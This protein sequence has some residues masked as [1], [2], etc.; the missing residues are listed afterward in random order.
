MGVSLALV[1]TWAMVYFYNVFSTKQLGATFAAWWH[2][3]PIAPDLTRLIDNMLAAQPLDAVDVAADGM[4]EPQGGMWHKYH[5]LPPA[6]RAWLFD[7]CVH[8]RRLDAVAPPH[9]EGCV[10]WHSH[11]SDTLL[12]WITLMLDMN[13]DSV[14]VSR[15]SMASGRPRVNVVSLPL[16]TP[17]TGQQQALDHIIALSDKNDIARCSTIVVVYGETGVGKSTLC[18]LW[19]Q[20][21]LELRDPLVVR[22]YPNVDILRRG[23]DVEELV[24]RYNGAHS[25][26]VLNIDEIDIAIDRVTGTVPSPRGHTTL[27]TEDKRAFRDLMDILKRIPHSLVFLTTNVTPTE[28]FVRGGRDPSLLGRVDAFMQLT[29]K[30]AVFTT[31]GREAA[32]NMSHN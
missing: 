27:H 7:D 12:R 4:L 28:L 26:A 31:D 25:R 3:F 14:L 20:R 10:P 17:R 16:L 19:K 6:D 32:N 8:L 23:V 11:G 5:V 18:Q 2:V 22:C 24:L 1:K 9:Y 30:T 15:I 13:A 29:Q 21:Q